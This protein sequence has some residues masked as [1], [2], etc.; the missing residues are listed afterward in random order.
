VADYTPLGAA[1]RALQD[2]WAGAWPRPLHV[3]VMAAFTVALGA[4][5]AK[6]FRWRP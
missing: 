4:L 2:A 3:A 5:A 6:N 1:S